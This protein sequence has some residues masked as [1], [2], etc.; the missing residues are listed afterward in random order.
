VTE[1]KDDAEIN[2]SVANLT[3]GKA[4]GSKWDIHYTAVQVYSQ[5]TEVSCS[6]CKVLLWLSCFLSSYLFFFCFFV[7]L[8]LFVISVMCV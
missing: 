1:H 7:L 3:V 4:K 8:L 2:T 5:H 6:F